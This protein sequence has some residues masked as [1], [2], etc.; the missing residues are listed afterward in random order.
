[1]GGISFPPLLPDLFSC[2]RANHEASFLFQTASPRA[3]IP[4]GIREAAIRVLAVAST[5]LVAAAERG[6]HQP[7]DDL[8]EARPPARDEG[9]ST[10]RRTPQG[11]DRNQAPTQPLH[12]SVSEKLSYDYDRSDDRQPP[13]VTVNAFEPFNL[14]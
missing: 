12:S 3:I 11:V 9:A 13:S 5:G 7:A 1:M 14:E 6:P 8:V 2:T 10:Q 4:S